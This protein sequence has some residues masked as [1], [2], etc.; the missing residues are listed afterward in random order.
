VA[1]LNS[2]VIE[3]TDNGRVYAM[4]AL[5]VTVIQISTAAVVVQVLMTL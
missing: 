3:S 4:A 1:K 5:V 2:S